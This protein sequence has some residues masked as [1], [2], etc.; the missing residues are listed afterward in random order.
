MTRDRDR[1]DPYYHGTPEG[2]MPRDGGTIAP[3]VEPGSPAMR[4]MAASIAAEMKG[5][6]SF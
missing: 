3:E 2:D 5:D 6:P 1:R 4:D